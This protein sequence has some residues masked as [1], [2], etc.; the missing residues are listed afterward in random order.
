MSQTKAEIATKLEEIQSDMAELNAKMNN[1]LQ[2]AVNKIFGQWYV[3][4]W[5]KERAESKAQEAWRNYITFEPQVD[6]VVKA[7]V[8]DLADSDAVEQTAPQY[9]A[10]SFAAAAAAVG[11]GELG[12]T[13][14]DWESGNT[15][16]YRNAVQSLPTKLQ[17]LK[18]AVE[19]VCN[20]LTDLK[21]D[22]DSYF[23]GLLLAL[24]S[25]ALAVAGAVVAVVGL[26][27]AIPSGGAGLVV[28]IIGLVIAVLALVPAVAA[29]FVLPDMDAARSTTAS[30]LRDAAQS[31]RNSPW[32]AKPALDSADWD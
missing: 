18:D 9:C 15:Q 23:I 13:G 5:L 1:A 25:L 30:R 10:V 28:A 12:P 31:V 3:P 6:P 29:Y 22:Y 4:D 20:L 16:N 27:L 7:I 14:D 24:I 21:G 17:N 2:S 11:P 19:E 26:V 8:R 32:P